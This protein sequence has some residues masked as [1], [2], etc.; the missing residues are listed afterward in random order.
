MDFYYLKILYLW[1]F[2]FILGVYWY[3]HVIPQ[4]CFEGES[5]QMVK[6]VAEDHIPRPNSV[7]KHRNGPWLS[8]PHR[9]KKCCF[10]NVPPTNLLWLQVMEEFP[11][12]FN[13]PQ[14]WQPQK[15]WQIDAS[16]KQLGGHA[17]I[18]GSEGRMWNT[19]WWND[20]CRVQTKFTY[21]WG[22]LW[23]FGCNVGYL[24]GKTPMRTLCGGITAESR[25]KWL[26]DNEQMTQEVGSSL[27]WMQHRCVIATGHAKQS[28]WVKGSMADTCSGFFMLFK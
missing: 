11:A 17:R 22:F 14:R 23:D 3:V 26:V 9:C 12:V 6:V 8:H 15:L 19:I 16:L 27:C 18:V 5:R 28:D 4:K 10:V 20:P 13:L 7:S 24:P 2:F 1:L 21:F 25:A